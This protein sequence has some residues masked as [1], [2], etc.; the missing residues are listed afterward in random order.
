M[1]NAALWEYRVIGFGGLLGAKGEQ[2]EAGLNELGLQGWEV[3]AVTLSH[4]GG[5]LLAFAKRPLSAAE[6]R[7]RREW[8]SPVGQAE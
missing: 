7:K 5:K 6:R 4:N 8:P 1:A 2:I 3:I